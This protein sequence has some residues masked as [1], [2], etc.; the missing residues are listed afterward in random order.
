M[1]EDN[2]M[3][4]FLIYVA[5]AVLGLVVAAALQ[6]MRREHFRNYMNECEKHFTFEYCMKGWEME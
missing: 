2:K 5:S 4:W 6:D 3:R 1:C